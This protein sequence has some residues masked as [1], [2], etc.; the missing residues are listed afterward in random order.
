[1]NDANPPVIPPPLPPTQMAQPIAEPVAP[2]PPAAPTTPAAPSPKASG[3]I[4]ASIV[5]VILALLLIDVA[6]ETFLAGSPLLIS[7]VVV[8]VLVIVLLALLW[9]R[10]GSTTRVMI[11]LAGLVGLVSWAVVRVGAG[12]DPALRLATLTL[13]RIAVAIT[14]VG[15][16]L[17]A[18]TPLFLFGRRWY[19]GLPLTMIG[20]Y[21]L[22]PLAR[23]LLAAAAL[24]RVLAG[25][26]D[27]QSLPFWLQGGY[28]GGAVLLPL[29]LLL[30]LGGL[31]MA[32]VKRRSAMWPAVAVVLLLSVSLAAAA[33]LVRTGRPTVARIVVAPVLVRVSVAPPVAAAEQSGGVAVEGGTTPTTGGVTPTAAPGAQPT[34]SSSAPPPAAVAPVAVAQ[35]G[36]PLSNKTI[37]VRVLGVRSVPSIGSQTASQGREF[38]VVDT[39]WKNL[40][41]LAKVNRKKASDRT[42]G[43]GSLGFGGGAT[44][45]EKASDEANTTL[46]PVKFEIGPLTKHVWLLTDGPRA[47]VLDVDATKET[48]GHLGPEAIGIPALNDVKTGSLVYE[49]PANSQ[50]LSLLVLDSTNGHLLISIRGAAPR[51]ASGLGG[52]SRSNSAVDLAVTGANWSDGPAG[53]PGTRTLIV[54]VKGISRKEAIADI[55][56]GEWGFLQTEQGCMARP[57]NKLDSIARPLSPMGRFP[58]FAP[59]EGQLAFVVPADSKSAT[60]ML[61][62]REPGGSLDLPVVG[63]AKPSWTSPETTITDGDV[64]KVHRLPGTAVPAGVPPASSG[65]ERIALDLVVENLRPADGIELQLDQQFRLVTPDGKRIAP[66]GDSAHAPCSLTGDVVPAASSRRFTLVYDVPPGQPLQFEYRGFNVKSELV[67]VR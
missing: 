47:E 40:I 52:V 42:A 27:W 62:V 33:E 45:Q 64:L 46:E 8:E 38:V 30:A 44:A 39:S 34:E 15:V 60:L 65:S 18:L 10:V 54:S 31:G 50:S 66:S 58:P 19:F 25:E 14:V 36:Q 17:A 59:S 23:A 57:E 20:L 61:R 32:L 63:N 6:V 12:A 9:S 2:V 35:I 13:P 21:A 55:P 48:P 5:S 49:A 51:P 7:V 22:V 37:E 29:A 53:R 3:G 28:L 67:K 56:F 1:M 4:G 26:F 43:A 41:P 11:P 24:P 16:L